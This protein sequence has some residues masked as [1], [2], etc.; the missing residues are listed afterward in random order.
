MASNTKVFELQLKGADKAAKDLNAVAKS[1]G[2][3]ANQL[4]NI[5]Q[6]IA[7]QIVATQN[8]TKALQEQQQGLSKTSDEYARLSAEIESNERAVATLN[9]A[10]TETTEFAGDSFEQL[11]ALNKAL[12]GVPIGSKAFNSL[13]K[14]VFKFEQRVEVGKRGLNETVGIVAGFGATAVG[15]FSQGAAAFQA[16]GGSGEDSL[17]IIKDLETATAIAGAAQGAA[18]L[19]TDGYTAA[20]A[21]QKLAVVAADKATKIWNATLLLNPVV[22]IAAGVLALGAAVYALSEA[23]SES[24]GET[25]AQTKALNELTEAELKARKSTNDLSTSRLELALQLKQIE[26]QQKGLSGTELQA[27]LLQE[28][29]TANIQKRKVAIDNWRVAQRGV[30]LALKQETDRKSVV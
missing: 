10:L 2:T 23:F 29:I 15:A 21:A 25:K 13:S 30:N 26:L 6:A 19:I 27:A 17:A 3:T 5:Q 1:V 9:N 14:E 11:T 20:I 8:S 7:K 16:F 28:Q 12:D 24:E 22:A 18:T 4:S